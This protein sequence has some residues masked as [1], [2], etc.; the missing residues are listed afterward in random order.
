MAVHVLDL[1]L[2]ISCQIE[3][4]IE[5]QQLTAKRVQT[6]ERF[7]SA[8]SKNTQIIACLFLEH[9]QT[10]PVPTCATGA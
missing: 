8:V 5:N 1:L 2:S 4:P 9:S 10:R 6:T 7:V 3:A